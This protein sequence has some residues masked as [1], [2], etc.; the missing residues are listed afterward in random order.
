[1]M[2]RKSGL[3]E[4]V[5]DIRA[6]TVSFLHALSLGHCSPGKAIMKMSRQKE[7]SSHNTLFMVPHIDPTPEETLMST[8]YKNYSTLLRNQCD[9]LRAANPCNAFT[10]MEYTE[11]FKAPEL[12]H[13]V[14]ANDLGSA[15]VIIKHS[16]CEDIWDAIQFVANQKWEMTIAAFYSECL[17]PTRTKPYHELLPVCE[18]HCDHPTICFQTGR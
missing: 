9:K 10:R 4:Y 11:G 12:G 18:Y 16:F 3:R 15:G 7:G 6:K 14:C 17:D 5:E 2:Q 13:P 8:V 1:M